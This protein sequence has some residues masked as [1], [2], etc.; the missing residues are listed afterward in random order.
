MKI[1]VVLFLSLLSANIFAESCITK[2]EVVEFQNSK[3]EVLININNILSKVGVERVSTTR[4]SYESTDLYIG[5]V[6]IE[7]EVYNI[8]FEY[9]HS[10][11]DPHD[12]P[13]FS[14]L[15]VCH[16]NVLK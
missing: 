11:R 4:D 14:N 10:Q 9:N 16:Q 12:Y 1:V 5:E 3:K 13:W 2:P 7:N 15:S 6:T 8:E